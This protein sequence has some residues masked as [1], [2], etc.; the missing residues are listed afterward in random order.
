MNEYTY[1]ESK[2]LIEYMPVIDEYLPIKRYFEKFGFKKVGKPEKVD[3]SV[4][5]W[6]SYSFTLIH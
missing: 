5:E 1:S 6:Q 2:E 4:Y 3:W